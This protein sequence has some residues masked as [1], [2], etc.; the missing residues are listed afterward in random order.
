[1]AQWSQ[2][3]I[4][5]VESQ[6]F[7]VPGSRQEMI[8][9]FTTSSQRCV[10]KT[11]PEVVSQA[12]AV[13][14][15]YASCLPAAPATPGVLPSTPLGRSAMSIIQA[16]R[17]GVCFGSGKRRDLQRRDGQALHS[18]RPPELC[19]SHQRVGGGEKGPYY[20]HSVV[21]VAG[22]ELKLLNGPLIDTPLCTQ[23]TSV[24]TPG[25][26]AAG[27]CRLPGNE[28]WLAWARPCN[29][30][31]GHSTPGGGRKC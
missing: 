4:V 31:S 1:M 2:T 21:F 5:L 18:N 20:W 17:E 23:P 3:L 13:C 6:R 7:L 15:P 14:P 16:R 25:P 26:R 11:S 12:I 24:P 30:T 29:A 28:R 9:T 10:A 19:S 8:S 27:S 22:G